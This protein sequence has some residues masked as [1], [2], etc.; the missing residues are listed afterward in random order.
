MAQDRIVCLLPVFND[1]ASVDLLLQQID[2]ALSDTS[3]QIRILLV[4]DGS[5]DRWS[6]PGSQEF[7]SIERIEVLSLRRNIGHQRAICV[8]LCYIEENSDADL[9]VVMDSDGEDNPEDIP[10]LLDKCRA[11]SNDKVVFAERAKRSEN[12]MFRLLYQVY[13]FIHFV[14]VGHRI[15]VGN[16]SVIPTQA[17]RSLTVVPELWSHY[18]AAV[19]TARLPHCGVS[20]NRA[21]RLDGKSKMGWENLVVHGLSAISAFSD[22]VGVRLL[23]IISPLIA[24]VLSAIMIT[25]MMHFFYRGLDIP[26]WAVTLTGL[27][28]MLL[29]NLLFFVFLFC[30]LVLNGRAHG[31]FLPARDYALFVDRL[32]QVYPSV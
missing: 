1:W 22:R 30:F 2:R 25:L 13:R 7:R 20:T 11:E 12:L 8:G 27:L 3:N 26:I 19:F 21:Q 4:D 29:F 32:I 9:V 24:V 14:L 23:T 15:R 31:S 16:F 10:R 18:A 5:S 6:E 17:L 28:L